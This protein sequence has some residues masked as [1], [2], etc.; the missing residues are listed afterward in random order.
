MYEQRLNEHAAELN[1]NALAKE[2]AGRKREELEA[3]QAEQFRVGQGG[4]RISMIPRGYPCFLLLLALDF[5]KR[6]AVSITP[7]Q[8]LIL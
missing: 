1:A 2:A 7:L 6:A 8:K 3:S 4:K 5:W